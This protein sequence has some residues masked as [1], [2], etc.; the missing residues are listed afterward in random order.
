MK[1]RILSNKDAPSLLRRII[2][3]VLLGPAPA[4]AVRIKADR[5]HKA[6]RD[7]YWQERG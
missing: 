4:P 1:V 7:P 6:Q 3:Q 2:G 5:C